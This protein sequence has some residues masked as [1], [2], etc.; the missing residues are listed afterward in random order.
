LL[1]KH[2]WLHL[3]KAVITMTMSYVAYLTYLDEGAVV[4]Q[5]RISM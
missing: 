2:T 5:N 1:D 4:T 3:I